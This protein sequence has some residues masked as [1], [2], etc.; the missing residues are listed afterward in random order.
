MSTL[1]KGVVYICVPAFGGDVNSETTASLMALSKALLANGYDYYYSSRSYPDIG[2]LR[3]MFATAWFDCTDAEW[4]LQIDADMSFGPQLVLDML[5]FDKALVGCLYPQKTLPIRFH[6]KFSDG[7]R[8]I[9]QGHLKV[10]GMGF[11]VTLVRRDCMQELLDSGEAWSDVRLSFHSCR[12]WF[13]A[14]GMTRV[15]RAFEK[16]RTDTG[17][18]S[19]DLSF[20]RRYLNAG[21]EVWANISHE[22][23]HI[24][25]YGFKGK[26]ADVL[27]HLE[28]SDEIRPEAAERAPLLQMR[29]QDRGAKITELRART[30]G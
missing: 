3:D 21:G 28:S 4:M 14:M 22:I 9:E 6:V 24:G 30:A 25:Q 12:D 7:P 16:Y 5:A 23:T 17:D 18:L 2:E 29:A 13:A 27:Q 1:R 26:F 15:I 10:D 8:R 11:G 20:C 19:E